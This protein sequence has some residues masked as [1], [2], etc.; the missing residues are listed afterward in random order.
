MSM[1]HDNWLQ[2]LRH[3]PTR[4][5]ALL[6]HLGRDLDVPMALVSILLLLLLFIELSGK[7]DRRWHGLVAAGVWVLWALVVL[8]FLAKL[9]LAP[10]KWHYLRRHW[11]DVLVV[12]FPFLGFHRVL[13]ARTLLR[14][15]LVI[16]GGRSVGPYLAVLK[17]RKLG[18]LALISVL[19]LLIA[20]ALEDIF[21]V[22]VPGS[23]ITSF[24]AALWWAAATMTTVGNQLYPVTT[25]GAIVAFLLMLYAIGVFSYLTSAVAS[26]LIA[27]DTHQ[28]ADRTDSPSVGGATSAPA[29]QNGL[30]L[31]EDEIDALRSISQRVERQSG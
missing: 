18:H 23:T 8:E 10:N 26:A 29:G 31:S 5:E 21:E 4:R 14:V 7:I 9:A 17:K 12:V 27:G 16:F 24:E 15:P 2:R 13:I 3:D 1:H 20:A 28:A 30:H 22:G 6:V 11:L 25:G 19:V